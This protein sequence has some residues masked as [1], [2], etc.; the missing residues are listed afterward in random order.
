[1]IIFRYLTKEVLVT[2]AA[3]T[4]ILLLIILSN[5]L[6]QL[7]KRAAAGQIPVDIV[8]RMVLMEIPNLI[9]LLMPLGLFMALLIAYGRLYVDNEM[10]VL[11]ACGFSQSRLLVMTMM[12]AVLVALIVGTLVMFVNPII[13][14]HR[15][16]LLTGLSATTILKGIL[17]GRFELL[18]GKGRVI[19][20]AEK[21]R[22]QVQTGQVF[23]AEKSSTDTKETGVKSW[24]VLMAENA[25]VEQDIDSDSE[26]IVLKNGYQ[27]MGAP[28]EQNYR[29]VKFDTYYARVPQQAPYIRKVQMAMPMSQLWPIN[30]PDHAKAAE[31]QWRL[32]APL[33]TVVLALL[34]VPMSRVQPRQGKY[35]K[36]L[37]SIL[38][39]IVYANM[40]FVT[41]DWI[42]AGKVS[43]FMGMWWLH[44]LVL[45]LAII[46][47]L[48][49]YWRR[50]LHALKIV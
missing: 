44:G 4:C 30:N 9:G 49:P 29:I 1:M 38:I 3:L 26:Q 35:A 27:Y 28:G 42:A 46:L 17:P 24:D 13:S 21:Y 31:I 25:Y 33:M 36:L 22:D 43:S 50:C 19:Y 16:Y 8:I 47:L 32:S 41:K 11:A 48:L 7:L 37:P 2:L 6:V 18:G 5:Q 45:S 12:L 15:D 34:A 10:V 14:K 20:V 23:I 39:Y 40:I